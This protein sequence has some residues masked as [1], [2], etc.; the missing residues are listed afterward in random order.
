VLPQDRA[1]FLVS[2]ALWG[3]AC[4]L[5]ATLLR[6]YAAYAASLAGYTA[7]IVASDQLGAT[8]GLNGQAFLLAV[9]R[10]SEIC[11]GIV[12]AGVVL[13]G[14]DL[15]GARR[16]LAALF[17]AL[18]AEIT[19][20]FTG[21]LSLTG[22]ALSETQPVRRELIRRV[23]AIDPVIDEAI[24]ESSRLRYHSPVLQA[25]VDGWFAALAAWRTVAVHLAGLAHEEAGREAEF[26]LRT[27]PQGAASG[28]GA[29]RADPLDRRPHPSAPDVRG[30]GAGADRPARRDAV[31]A[32]AC[33]PYG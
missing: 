4:A 3:A 22:P 7:A 30:G 9:T 17:A 11:I 26:V 33:R 18:S 20:R 24:G 8:G 12:C 31:A 29:G 13:A 25:A 2:L 1:A 5:V 14:T 32:P 15:G 21:T 28:A 23:T 19:G 27:L 6:N 16:R 10:A